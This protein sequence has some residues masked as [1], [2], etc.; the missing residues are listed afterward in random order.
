MPWKVAVS[1]L[2]LAET[3]VE[4]VDAGF[5][6]VLDRAEMR[7]VAQNGTLYILGNLDKMDRTRVKTVL[8]AFP[9]VRDVRFYTE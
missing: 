3:V 7:M 9:G 8:K 1:D 4:L 6:Q 5:P 2:L